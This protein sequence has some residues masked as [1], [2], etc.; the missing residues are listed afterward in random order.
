LAEMVMPGYEDS[1]E[2]TFKRGRRA[3]VVIEG[4][5]ILASIDE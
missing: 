1:D 2:A 3:T 4:T 5:V